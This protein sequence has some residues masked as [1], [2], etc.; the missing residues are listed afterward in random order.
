M[1]ITEIYWYCHSVF[2]QG[3][4]RVKKPK[5]LCIQ[6]VFKTFIFSPS[7]MDTHTPVELNTLLAT[8]IYDG[9][10][11]RKKSLQ[12]SF[13]WRSFNQ[14]DWNGLLCKLSTGI[15]LVWDYLLG[16]QVPA[17][18][19]ILYMC[20]EIT[21]EKSAIIIIHVAARRRLLAINSCI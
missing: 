4:Q 11:W 9:K 13:Y 7:A 1:S 2:C 17:V 20:I 16:Y 21:G 18:R 10:A 14:Y 3:V 12:A 8:E 15:M 5:L 6:F 19:Q